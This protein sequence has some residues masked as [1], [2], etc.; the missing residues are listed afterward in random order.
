MSEIRI[1]QA[2]PKDA[3]LVAALTIQAARADGVPPEPGFMDRFAETWL[4]YRDQHPIWFAEL[5]GEHAGVLQS[6][7]VRPLPWPG[8][9]GGGVLVL[10]LLFVRPDRRDRGVEQALIEA[11]Q[12]FCGTRGLKQIMRRPEAFRF[13]SG[14]PLDAIPLVGV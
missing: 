8:R 14:K 7:R 5:D 12:Q 13:W 2:G 11:A 6:S 9:T 3:L 4:E 1:R 10:D